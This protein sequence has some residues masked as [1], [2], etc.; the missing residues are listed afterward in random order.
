ML[1][2]NTSTQAHKKGTITTLFDPITPTSA[3]NQSRAM[4]MGSRPLHNKGII[5]DWEIAIFHACT[6][7][8]HGPRPHHP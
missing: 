4:Q 1:D 5:I 6:P 8:P 7:L 2:N 3:A